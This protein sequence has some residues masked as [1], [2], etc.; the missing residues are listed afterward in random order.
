M[1]PA[2]FFSGDMN[3]LVLKFPR[4]SGLLGIRPH[5]E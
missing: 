4:A 3:L 1:I 5:G 2:L